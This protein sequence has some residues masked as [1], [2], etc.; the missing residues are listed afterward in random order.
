M[1]WLI[2]IWKSF[3]F[4]LIAFGLI[5]IIGFTNTRHQDRRINDVMISVDN[6]F[7]NY[8][9][10]QQDVLDLINA[11]GKDYLLSSDIGALDLKEL[12]QRIESHQFVEDAQ[13]YLDLSGNL[14][15]D[16]KQNR[17]I[18]RIINGN[19][20]DF[21]I[22]TKGDVL[23]ESS[24]YTARVILIEL[25]NQYWLSEFNIKDSKGGE[26]VFELLNYLVKNE[27]W[28]T[29]IAGMKIEKDMD[30]VLY[31][32]V[33]K[34]EIEFGKAEELD[35]KFRRLETFYKKILPYKGW[36]TYNTVNLKFKD[37][38]VCK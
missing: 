3:Q 36:N 7:H 19:G 22:G 27:F 28:R 23:P 16:V 6:Q 11:E 10:D 9:I 4:G 18:A 32:Q 2:K 25:E 24:H 26:E 15:I 37:Q 33:T 34:Q 17:P 5:V 29:Q 1:N 30:I 21:Y 14:S 20:K 13:A 38:I 12:E 35:S 31:P 8:F